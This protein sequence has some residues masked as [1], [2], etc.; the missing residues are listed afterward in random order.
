MNFWLCHI[1]HSLVVFQCSLLSL[2]LPIL[3]H[4][5]VIVRL[6]DT[7]FVFGK[8]DSEALDQ[9]ELMLDL[10]PVRLCLLLGFVQLVG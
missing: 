7:N 3:L 10:S 5:D 4:M 9:G 8:F 1:N 2:D 6:K